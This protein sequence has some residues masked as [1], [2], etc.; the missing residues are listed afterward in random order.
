M[1]EKLSILSKPNKLQQ[2]LV[3]SWN[4]IQPEHQGKK[5]LEWYDRL[6]FST[7]TPEEK[8]V[9]DAVHTFLKNNPKLVGWTAVATEAA[10]L[11]G[12]VVGFSKLKRRKSDVSRFREHGSLQ[13]IHTRKLLSEYID[14]KSRRPDP[15][16]PEAGEPLRDAMFRLMLD[17][18]PVREHINAHTELLFPS[19]FVDVVRFTVQGNKDQVGNTWWDMVS[20]AK[21]TGRLP[22]EELSSHMMEL[23]RRCGEFQ[24]HSRLGI[25]TSAFVQY[26]ESAKWPMLLDLMRLSPGPR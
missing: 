18:A 24:A 1:P 25:D 6:K 8:K 5:A 10:L 7:A 16:G 21:Q 3:G 23:F 19:R 15:T 4:A 11:A 12:V 13:E 22:A 20:H 17:V 14:I 2:V 9:K 26:W